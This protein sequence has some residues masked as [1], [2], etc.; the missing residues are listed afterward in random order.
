MKKALGKTAALCMAALLYGCA[1]SGDPALSI[2]A[3][4]AAGAAELPI[5]TTDNP[6]S[7][8]PLA[9]I[10]EATLSF[11]GVG[12]M[13]LGVLAS[14]AYDQSAKVTLEQG[15]PQRVGDDLTLTFQRFI[16]RQGREKERMEVEVVS[17]G[18]LR[19]FAYPKL[20]VNDRTRQ[21]MA[22]PH[23]YKALLRDLYISPIQFEPGQPPGIAPAPLA[24]VARLDRVELAAA[25]QRAD[26]ATD[27]QRTRAGQLLSES[28]ERKADAAPRICAARL[29]CSPRSEAGSKRPSRT[30]ARVGQ[31]QLIPSVS[32]GS[33]YQMIPFRAAGR[34]SVQLRTRADSASGSDRPSTAWNWSRKTRAV[35]TPS[36]RMAMIPFFLGRE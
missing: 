14:S 31:L 32:T 26:G 9:I 10:A 18:G 21:L 7:E 17:D 5:L 23:V 25:A 11:L 33:R 3:S 15:V 36:M 8:D 19:Y 28:N 4:E 22:N 27:E 34:S 24:Q 13:L 35:S 29:N 12:V 30:A 6:R 2:A 16:P 20:F 1:T